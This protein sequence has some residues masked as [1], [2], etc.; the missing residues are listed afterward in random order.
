MKKSERFVAYLEDLRKDRG[1]M[2]ALRRI[3]A[4]NP[5]EWGDARAYRYVEPFVQDEDGWRWQAYYLVAGLYALHP[6][7][8]KPSL[9]EAV[10]QVWQEEDR[11][12]SLEGRF[13]AL[14][15]ADSDQL[16]DRLR[17]VVAYLKSK[18]KGVNYQRLLEDL[19]GWFSPDRR[20]QRR[21]AREFYRSAEIAPA[22]SEETQVEVQS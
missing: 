5:G 4:F 16:P 17:R 19:L 18:R 9:A 20:V 2:A 13:L 3:L 15:D 7:G 12:P 14:L 10:S 22:E 6:D 21:W 8:E 1:A 11:P